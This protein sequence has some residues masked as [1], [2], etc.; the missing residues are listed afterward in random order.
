MVMKWVISILTVFIL[1]GC[2]SSSTVEHKKEVAL[3]VVRQ[4]LVEGDYTVEFFSA[5]PQASGSINQVSSQLNLAASG[6][7]AGSINITGDANF[8]KVKGR[9]V[10]AHLPFYDERHS[11]ARPNAKQEAIEFNGKSQN[12]RVRKIKSNQSIQVK[13]E[14][15]DKNNPNENYKV[16]LVVFTNGKASVHISSSQRSAMAYTGELKEALD[17]Y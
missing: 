1:S 4:V 7:N 5:M 17:D 6:S 14:I 13:F 9:L 11:G 10:S 12:H 8:L 16:S 2:G 15:P 3:K